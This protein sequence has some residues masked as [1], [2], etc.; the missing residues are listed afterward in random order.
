MVRFRLDWLHC[1]FFYRETFVVL[2]DVDESSLVV[3][4][5]LEVFV[6]ALHFL[7]EAFL[8]EPFRFHFS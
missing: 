4:E 7:L 1:E 8:S 6:E 2:I 5:M 3:A